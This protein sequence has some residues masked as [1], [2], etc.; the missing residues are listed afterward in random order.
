MNEE[1]KQEM[2]KKNPPNIEKLDAE[3]ILEDEIF[4]YLIALPNS[5]DKTRTIEKIRTKAKEF[6]VIRAFNSIY[7]QKSQEYIQYLKSRGGNVIKFTDCPIEDLKCGQWNA[8][9]AGVYKIDYTAT[10]QPIKIK[11]C[12]HPILPVEIINNIDTNTEKVKI[13]FYKRRKWQYAIV[14]KKIIASNTAI[15]QLANRGIEVNSENAKNLVSYLAD[16]IELNNIETTDGITHLGWMDKD[17]IPYTS[18]YKY[19]G[20]T[21]YKNIFESVSEKGNYETWKLQMRKLREKSRT[22]RFLMASSFASPLVKIF[23]INPFVVHLWGKSSNGKTVAQ[24]ICASI[25]G[26]PAKG[27]LLSSLDSTKVASERL[28]NFLRNMPLILDELQITKTKYKTYDSLIYELTEG[29]GRDRGTVDGGLTETTEWDNIIIVSGEEP[30]TNSSSKEGVKNRVIEIEE[31]EKIVENGNKVVNLILNNYGFAGKEFIEIIQNKEDLFDE[32][33]TLV[34]ELKKDTNSPKQINAIATI[35]LA[36]KIV[37]DFIFKDNSI[38]LEEAKE[39][40]TIDIDEADRYIDLII[41]IANANI[42][43]FYDSSNNFPPSGQVWGKLEKTTD[44]KGAVIYY[45]FIPNKLYE[46]LNENNINW[47]G[48]KKKMASKEYVIVKNGK[49]QVPVRMPNGVQRM[50]RI[51]NIHLNETPSNIQ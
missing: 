47:D 15:I 10:M 16:I 8:D 51:K 48:I 20:D 41:D 40:F 31:N 22:L 13:A 43:N 49:Y 9:D 44:G 46:I 1:L 14:E 45:D 27:K 29:K 24:M 6:K 25:W 38:T 19:D 2:L 18:K 39:Y 23:Q 30:I 7:K 5:P 32:Y 37:S 3:S 17:F 34:E 28:C 12:P 21:A 50:I 4:D 42:N 26:N 36:D 33:N 11:A 35:L